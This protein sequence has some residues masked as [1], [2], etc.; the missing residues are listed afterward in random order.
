MSLC[1]VSAGR[2][3]APVPC[4]GGWGAV[5]FGVLLVCTGTICRSPLAERLLTAWP[6]R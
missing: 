3:A 2:L 5:T 1:V 4:W 6:A